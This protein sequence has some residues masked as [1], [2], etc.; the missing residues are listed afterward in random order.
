MLSYEKQTSNFDQDKQVA[1]SNWN[2][3]SILT[4]VMSAYE[5][6]TFA[7]VNG[8]ELYFIDKILESNGQ[9]QLENSSTHSKTCSA[10]IYDTIHLLSAPSSND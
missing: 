10:T 2:A 3:Y 8:F 4:F 7:F 1:T 9:R 5:F 6:D